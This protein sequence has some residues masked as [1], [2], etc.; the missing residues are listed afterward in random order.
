MNKQISDIS[1][2]EN[3]G[4]MVKILKFINSPFFLTF[5]TGLFIAFFSS[6]LSDKFAQ[7]KEKRELFNTNLNL[8]ISTM[9]KFARVTAIYL[10]SSYGMRKRQI[11]L[12][13]NQKN[14]K[15]P[16]LEYSDGRNF[17][18]TRNFYEKQK[19]EFNKLI[20]AD[21]IC[22]YAMAVF[23]DADNKVTDSIFTLDETLD[24][25]I[26]T[27]DYKMLKDYFKKA[28]TQYQEVIKVMGN[29]IN[30]LKKG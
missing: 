6:C 10:Q 30:L 14:R 27:Y 9:E 29:H 28:D 24:G 26:T 17:E 22:A 3:E 13:K 19:A 18:K 8:K 21:A 4:C 23:S 11:W 15:D 5:I 7:D 20:P 25:Y 1:Q 12:K 2:K 16:S